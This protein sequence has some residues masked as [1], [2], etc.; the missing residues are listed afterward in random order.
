[1]P[2]DLLAAYWYSLRCLRPEQILGRLHYRLAWQLYPRFPSLARL[3]CGRAALSARP[4]PGFSCPPRPVPRTVVSPAE[5]IDWNPPNTPLLARFH[6]HYFDWAAAAEPAL[7]ARQV[8]NWI[9]S[10][11]PGAWPGWH[12]YPTSLRIVNWIRAFSSTLAP[13]PNMVASLATQ[14]AFLAA[15]LEFHLGGNHLL[16]NARALLAAGLYFDGAS[17][18][19]WKTTGLHLLRREFTA[20]IL[21]D[22][23]HFERSPWYHASMTALVEDSIHLLAANGCEVPPELVSAAARMTRFYRALRH[24]DG[25]LPLF[26]DALDTETSDPPAAGGLVS[27]PASG[28]YILDTAHGRLIADYGAPADCYNPAHQHA[29]IFSFE[30]SGGPRRVVTDFGTPTYEPGPARDRLRSTAAHNTVCVDGRD[31]FQVWAAFRVGRRARV[32]PVEERRQPQFHFLSAAHDGY[33][34]LGVEHRRSIVSIPDAGWLIVD[35]LAGRGSHRLE[36]F[37]HLAPGITPEI[38]AGRV[39]L[40]PLGWILL[41]FGF[42]APPVIT[43]DTYSPAIEV[44]EPSQTLVLSAGP[45]LPCRFGYFLGP[46]A[47]GLVWDGVNTLRLETPHRDITVRLKSSD[48]D[49]IEVSYN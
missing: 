16:E 36:S 49:S 32:G 27:F 8:E 35:D 4:R 44:I 13:A 42:A 23:G 7:L 40:L 34:H 22:G 37:V 28:Y 2:L 48:S 10:N 11:P 26:H 5:P 29:G 25:R 30:A 20:Q 1:M 3:A 46:G 12:P 39:C 18:A 33:H 19:R 14:A 21:P 6:L 17:A 43:A 24:P 41:P 45:Q 9:R 31:Q 38:R 47:S 15:N